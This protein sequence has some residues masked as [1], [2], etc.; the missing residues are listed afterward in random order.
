VLEDPR[1]HVVIGPVD[2]P[3]VLPPTRREGIDRGIGPFDVAPKVA[4]QVMG[5]DVHKD[6]HALLRRE[7][8]HHFERQH[9][10]SYRGKPIGQVSTKGWYAALGR[11]GIDHF[12]WHDLRHTWASWHVQN[13]TP[14]FALQELGGWESSEMVRRYAHLAADHLAPCADRQLGS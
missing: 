12:R 5:A 13:G 1:T 3:D 14:L 10:F 9:V 4:V 7:P 11:S 6:V 2:V 8:P